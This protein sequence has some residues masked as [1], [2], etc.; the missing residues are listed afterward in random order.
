MRFLATVDSDVGIVKKVNQDSALVKH[1]MVGDKEV[2]LAIV[3]DGMGGLK[4]GELASATVIREFE[5]WF[6]QELVQA[7]EECRSA[8]DAPRALEAIAG[9]WDA[10]LR[11]VNFRLMDYT[12]RTGGEQMG[13]TF[14][15]LLMLEDDYLIVHVGDTRVYHL[16]DT[17]RQLTTD[18]TFIARELAKGTMTVEQA[19]TDKRRNM[20][21]QCVGASSQ[22]EPQILQ[23]K[24]E[25]GCY[26]LC[27]DGFRHKISEDEIY[28]ALQSGILADK[29]VMHSQAL[30]LI[31]Q[32]KAR[33]ERDN[34][35]CI[36]VKT[37][38]RKS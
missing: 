24:V 18:H 32:V 35:T 22:M 23:G 9:R 37:E 34:I 13:T 14:T 38:G 10:I 12:S 11:D 30:K 7:L 28:E 19:Q 26:L 8:S 6:N 15:G 20:L 27:S 25:G 33:G 17:I 5:R 4:K 31:D 1:A 21:L 29:I 16:G 36:V 2:L 3:C